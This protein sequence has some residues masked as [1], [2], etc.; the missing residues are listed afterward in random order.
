MASPELTR[1]ELEK[2]IGRCALN[3]R[4]AFENIYKATSAVV[5][6]FLMRMLRDPAAAEEVLQDAYMQLWLKASSYN[7]DR[8]QPL[9]WIISLARYRALDYLRKQS[10]RN[11][12][13]SDFAIEQADALGQSDIATDSRLDQHLNI[14]LDKL[15]EEVRESV[16]KA[17][18]EGYTHQELSASMK[19]PIGTVKS[20]IRRGVQK[21]KECLHE[22]SAT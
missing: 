21:L 5:F 7:A 20:W 11:R 9:T 1:V 12:Y 15:Q 13:E 19:T 2:L 6:G 18:C 14:C 17:Y 8:G 16:L 10:T 3:D 22:L 4:R